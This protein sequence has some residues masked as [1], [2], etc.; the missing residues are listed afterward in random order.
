LRV[1][2]PA[3]GAPVADAL[4]LRELLVLAKTLVL[5]EVLILLETFVLLQKPQLLAL[6]HLSP[7]IANAPLT[8]DLC[9]R[10]FH[11]GWRGRILVQR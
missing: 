11:L 1:Q 9:R 10:I 5:P 4:V 2:R 8:I 6:L 7:R 3:C